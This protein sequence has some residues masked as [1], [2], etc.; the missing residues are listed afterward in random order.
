MLAKPVK[1][2]IEV[3]H[4][5]TPYTVIIDYAHTPDGVENIISAV[6]GFAKKRIITVIGCGGNRDAAKRPKM[7]H[8]A[9]EA[10]PILQ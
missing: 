10:F 9:E 7:G 6:R 5:N 1:G 4:I 2:R 8:I 3:M